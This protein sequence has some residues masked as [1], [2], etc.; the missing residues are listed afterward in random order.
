MLSLPRRSKWKWELLGSLFL[1]E[2][3]LNLRIQWQHGLAWLDP[4]LFGL[5]C[6]FQAVAADS[7]S[8]FRRYAIIALVLSSGLLCYRLTRF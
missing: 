2:A 4:L 3:L 5:G 6:L 1:A 8:R 7:L